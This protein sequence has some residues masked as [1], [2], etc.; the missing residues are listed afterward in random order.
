MLC[1]C[2]LC[3]GCS[4]NE[5]PDGGELSDEKVE[6]NF[7]VSIPE[8][9][10]V[11]TRTFGETATVQSLYVVVFDANGYIVEYAKAGV[12]PQTGNDEKPFKVSLHSSS[13]KRILHFIANY[14]EEKIKDLTFGSE[15]DLIGRMEVSGGQDAYWQRVELPDGIISDAVTSPKLKRIPLIRNFLKITV[16]SQAADFVFEGFSVIYTP[17]KGSVAPYNTSKGSF[18]RFVKT[19]ETSSTYQELTADRYRGYMP[20][21]INWEHTDVV[22]P[23]FQTEPF[24][25]YERTQGVDKNSTYLLV[26]GRWRNSG[27]STY[28]K[29]DI[30]YLNEV[31]KQ[32]VYYNLLRNF[33]YNVTITSVA[34]PGKTTSKEAADHPA[35]NNLSSSVDVSHLSNISNGIARLFVSYTDTTLVTSDAVKLRFK[36]YPNTQS[37]VQD[38]AQIKLYLNNDT[39]QSL[40]TTTP[41]ISNT[42]DADGWRTVTLQ[43][44]TISGAGEEQQS[45]VLYSPTTPLQ[46]GISRTVNFRL[47]QKYNVELSCSPQRVPTGIG[48][49]LD[50]K[51]TLSDEMPETMFP[52]SFLVESSTHGI[53]PN[54]TS[55]YMP[56]VTGYSIVAGKESSLSYGFMK[57]CTYEQYQR[58]TL[59]NGR[60]ELTCHFKTNTSASAGTI[61]VYNKYFE[62]KSVSFSNN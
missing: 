58:L 31:T 33:H 36:F 48:Q 55:E 15:R 61:Y 2:L 16:T 44:K 5:M 40:F 27:V 3:F 14:P 49:L 9:N 26:K 53:Y 37:S 12:F 57:T 54:P 28:Y 25:M 18:E 22:N 46:S 17:D 21:K 52:L 35:D 42:D 29:I 51:M 19:G 7:S 24:Y 59:T 23:V 60:R 32:P 20:Q 43:P 62:K 11:T 10:A 41:V 8:S 47:R 34:S 1:V 50:L 39:G 56:V 6:L 30:V 38:N 13:E 4:H 45:V